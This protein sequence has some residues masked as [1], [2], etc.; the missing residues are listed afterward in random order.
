MLLVGFIKCPAIDQF[1]YPLIGLL[2]QIGFFAILKGDVVMT[3]LIT[4]PVYILDVILESL[5]DSRRFL[6]NQNN[7]LPFLLP[8]LKRQP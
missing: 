3:N 5:I 6:V 2:V 1:L 4:Q 8:S 7:P